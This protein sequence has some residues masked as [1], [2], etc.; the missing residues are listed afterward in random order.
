MMRY[1]RDVPASDQSAIDVEI[2]HVRAH[3][4]ACTTPDDDSDANAAFVN[5]AIT[6]HL[7][8]DPDMMS[9]VGEID[10]E[11]IAPYLSDDYDPAAELPV[12]FRPYEEPDQDHHY[13]R[14]ALTAWR[15]GQ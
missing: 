13:D 11:P 2:E 4:S 3:L 9:I 6:S 5:V 1:R 15:A 7:D 8:G 10:A 12:R 14:E